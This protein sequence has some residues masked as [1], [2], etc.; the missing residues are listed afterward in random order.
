MF[1]EI[2]CVDGENNSKYTNTLCTKVCIFKCYIRWY[3]YLPP[4]FNRHADSEFKASCNMILM[5]HLKILPLQYDRKLFTKTKHQ[6][7]DNTKIQQ[8]EHH[9]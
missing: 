3:T 8:S 6:N 2:A 5:R 7:T 9:N 1:K 4:G